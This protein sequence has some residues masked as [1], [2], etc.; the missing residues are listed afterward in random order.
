[1]EEAEELS[2]LP[3]SDELVMRPSTFDS[4]ARITYE[5]L[6]GRD[7]DPG[8]YDSTRTLLSCICDVPILTSEVFEGC[9]TRY[10]DTGPCE[11]RVQ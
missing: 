10:I 5:P 4:A 7:H 1:M 2:L 8:I 9:Q 6:L 3:H 11:S